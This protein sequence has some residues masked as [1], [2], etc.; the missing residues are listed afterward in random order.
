[1]I[2]I[3]VLFLSLIFLGVGYLL[4]TRRMRL[5]SDI[6]GS[7]TASNVLSGGVLGKIDHLVHPLIFSAI[8]WILFGVYW[9]L[10]YPDYRDI[11][12]SVNSLFSLAAI[13]FFLFIAY[14]EISAIPENGLE[15]LR[16]LSGITVVSMGGYAILSEV[17]ALELALEYANAYLVSAFLTLSGFPSEAGGI[18]YSGNPLWHRTNDDLL[19]VPIL[20]SGDNE[21]LITLSCTAFSSLLL[22]LA[23]IISAREPLERRLRTALIIIPSLFLFNIIRMAMITYFT[24]AGFTSAAFAHHILGK[25][26]SLMVL[27]FLAWVLFTFLPSVLESVSEIFDLFS[28]HKANDSSKGSERKKP[29]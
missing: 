22:F 29:Q 25:T 13:P 20:H 8:G 15:G 18:D 27:F 19:S 9:A 17:P 28:M 4:R 26:G 3:L 16:F 12:D 5:A 24:Y 11:N 14:R 23:A 2:K 1:M 10:H 21:I 6:K 7:A